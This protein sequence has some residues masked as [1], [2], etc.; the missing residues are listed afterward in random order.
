MTTLTY[1]F[2]VLFLAGLFFYAKYTGS[3]YS[4]SFTNNNIEKIQMSNNK[5]IVLG[6]TSESAFVPYKK[7]AKFDDLD[8]MFDETHNETPV[9]QVEPQTILI[10]KTISERKKAFSNLRMLFNSGA[11][12]VLPACCTK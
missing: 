11:K 10:T 12:K 9:K 5:K 7:P 1:L 8:E 6:Y 2:I 3:K 4:E